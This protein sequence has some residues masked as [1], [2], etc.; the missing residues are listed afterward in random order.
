MKGILHV[1]G[2][3][4]HFL[5]LDPPIDIHICMGQEGE[6]DGNGDGP[7]GPHPCHGDLAWSRMVTFRPTIESERDLW[8]TKVQRRSQFPVCNKI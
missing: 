8:G 3:C 5:P 2:H 4:E 1:E 6:A 7:R